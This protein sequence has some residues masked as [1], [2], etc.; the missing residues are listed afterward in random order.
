MKLR[1]ISF[2]AILTVMIFSYNNCGGRK[3]NFD[4]NASL[5][6]QCAAPA[7]KTSAMSNVFLLAKVQQTQADQGV[8]C[9]DGSKGCVEICHVPPGNPEA[10]HTIVVG[11]AALDAHMAHKAHGSDMGD[12]MGSCDDPT[13]PGDV[14]ND[15]NDTSDGGMSPDDGSGSDGGMSPDDGSGSDGGMSPDDGSGTD[16]TNTSDGGMSPDNGG[17]TNGGTSTPDPTTVT[18]TDLNQ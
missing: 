9:D 3:V 1:L 17:S 4:A 13:S 14:A 10:R 2:I 11:Q 8:T 12:Y 18:C 7:L 6:A 5:K 15:G 16:G